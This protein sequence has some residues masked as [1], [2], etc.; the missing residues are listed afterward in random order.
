M[1]RQSLAHAGPVLRQ[2]VVALDAARSAPSPELAFLIARTFRVG[3]E[4]V[5]RWAA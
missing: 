5:F 1:T 2:S 4:D 3:V